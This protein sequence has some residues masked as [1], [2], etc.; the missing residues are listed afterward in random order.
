[1]EKSIVISNLNTLTTENEICCEVGGPIPV[2][3]I[4]PITDTFSN[5]KVIFPLY[6][7][8][9]TQA[10]FN[11]AFNSENV[12]KIRGK[13]LHFTQTEEYLKNESGAV[14]FGETKYTTRNDV[15]HSLMPFGVKNVKIIETSVGDVFFLSFKTEDALKKFLVIKKCCTINSRLYYSKR[16]PVIEEKRE[17][18]ELFIDKMK[19]RN[20]KELTIVMNEKMYQVPLFIAAAASSVIR[21]TLEKDPNTKEI[22]IENIIGPFDSVVSLL[23]G[24]SVDFFCIMSVYVLALIHS[25]MLLSLSIIIL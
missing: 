19:I 24:Q 9:T 8:T 13:I 23:S 10:G 2:I 16:F 14:L 22:M 20:E 15:L 7:L 6:V 1:M 12:F 3:S 5:K 21:K 4:T 25:W 11:E 17:K 18:N